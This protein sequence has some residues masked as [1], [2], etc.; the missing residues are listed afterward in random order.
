MQK[1]NSG[2]QKERGLHLKVYK[3]RLPF[4][5]FETLFLDPSPSVSS[6]SVGPKVKSCCGDIHACLWFKFK[7]LS[8]F[9]VIVEHRDDE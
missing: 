1:C 3:I 9:V 5:Y 4:F 2:W 8:F 6:S 7:Q